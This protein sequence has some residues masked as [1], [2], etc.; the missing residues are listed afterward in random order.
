MTEAFLNCYI[1]VVGANTETIKNNCLVFFVKKV[2]KYNSLL[3]IEFRNANDNL[4]PFF[5]VQVPDF[6]I[7]GV[8]EKLSEE[9][10]NGKKQKVY[11]N[12]LKKIWYVE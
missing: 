6:M 1:W 8:T 10:L 11:Y 5:E 7:Q 9:I 12:N 2:F 3:D 4:T